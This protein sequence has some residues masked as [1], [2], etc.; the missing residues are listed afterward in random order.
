MF[1]GIIVQ[2]VYPH[3]VSTKMSKMRPSFSSP[4]ADHY[5]SSTLATLGIESETPGCF[6][7]WLIGSLVHDLL[8]SWLLMSAT[9]SMG[10]GV[11]ARKY[12]KMAAKK[13]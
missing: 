2:S 7:H 10:L 5:V 4:S 6:A 11:R 8:P 3:H 1:P 9:K 13:E 12:K